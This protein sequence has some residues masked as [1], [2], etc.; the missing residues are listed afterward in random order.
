MSNKFGISALTQLEIATDVVFIPP[1]P[2]I[3]AVPPRMVAF[4]A[5]Q[6]M[7]LDSVEIFTCCEVGPYGFDVIGLEDPDALITWLRDSD[8]GVTA[9]MVPLPI[10]YVQEE[11]YS[12]L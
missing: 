1:E 2:P 6:A 11:L 10:V 8:Y 3:C 5:P 12:L 7:A 9:D 4:A